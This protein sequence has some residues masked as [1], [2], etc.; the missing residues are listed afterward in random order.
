MRFGESSSSM[1]PV[2]PGMKNYSPP[3]LLGLV[4]FPGIFASYPVPPTSS[5]LT[6]A[7]K[8]NQSYL[9]YSFNRYRPVI[10]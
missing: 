9:L 3:E 4:V 10:G 7:T 8:L 1:A 2:S 5:R 6:E